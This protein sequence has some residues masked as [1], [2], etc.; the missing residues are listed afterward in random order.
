MK[1]KLTLLNLLILCSFLF[2]QSTG[3]ISGK[4]V[5]NNN[6]PVFGANVVIENMGTGAAADINGDY[7]IINIPPGTY[8]LKI[9]AIGYSASRVENVEINGG[10]T[11]KVN[12]ILTTSAVELNEIVVQYKRPP[13]QKDLTAKQQEFDA[14]DLKNMPIAGTVKDVLT[15]QAGITKDIVTIPV[16]SQ[17]VFGQFATIPNDGLHFRG[18]R[19][20]E[21]LYLFDGIPVNDNLWG[22]YNLD[23]IGTYSLQSMRILTGT[24]G[25]Q[26]GE[27]MSGVVEMQPLDN[28]VD[29]YS[30]N[31]IAS[32]D[33][34]GENSGSENTRSY[35]ASVSGPVAGLKNFSFFLNAR[36]YQT[37]GY[38]FGY[39]YPDYVDSR[40]TDKT[41]SPQKVP[42]AFRDN[43]FFFGKLLYQPVDALKLGVGFYT[44]ETVNGMY[45]HFFKYNPYGTPNQYLD[46]YLGY[47]KVT[48]V[49][50]PSTYYEVILSD[51]SRSFDSHVY[52][53]P[54]QYAVIPQNSTS[55]FSISGED[56]VYF[57]SKFEKS[58]AQVTFSS[59]V[60]KQQFIKAGASYAKLNTQL[61]RLNP[62]GFGAIEDYDF[63]P[64][65]FSAYVNDKMEFEDIGMVIN[66]GLRYDYIDPN[67]TFIK[68][69]TSPD[70]EVGKVKARQYVSPRFGISYPIS[71]AAA[72]RFGYGHYYQYP[73]F[74]KAFQGMNRQ[75]SLYPS[76]DVNSV[77]GAIAKGDIEEE[78]TINYEV[79]VQL[80][81][82]DDISADITGFYRKTY[83]LIGITITEGYLRS[84]DVVKTQKYPIF[85]NV[86][87]ATVQGIE[88]S[89]QKRLTGVFSGFINYTYS[90][91]LVSSSLVLS[92]PQDV[93]RTF[94]ADWDQ[95]HTAS[96]GAIFQFPGDWGFSFL[97]SASSGLPYT[98]NQYRPNAERA[99][100]IGS[101]DFMAHKEFKLYGVGLRITGQVFNL[102]NRRNI[103]WVYPDS[104][105][106]GVDTN[107]ATSD[108]YTN[109]PTMWGPGRR[110]QLGL[111][112]SY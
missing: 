85:D 103:W 69:I 12:V 55:E 47:L 49:L 9:S 75:Y 17:P 80:K 82:T 28:V 88:I 59:Q 7:F 26:Y 66:A 65:K 4:I 29:K 35:E 97:G 104:G 51:Y 33:E 22:G 109:N 91:A 43:R 89:I 96:F 107:L 24:F 53:T 108:D 112:I 23:V 39:I 30:F 98:Y 15:K 19:T 11:T 16:T 8:N 60:T 64:T 54:E 74:Y 77:S 50:S 68:N 72:F 73:D 83:N 42:M 57:D 34:F 58:E 101:F 86:N 14:A 45:N 25:P 100:W 111:S 5:D 81:V 99:P 62:D 102:F 94:P 20:N 48:H 36:A 93:T 105:Q 90:E 38:V 31:A 71:D 1:L 79:G 78:K 27:A 40:G 67:R 52:D 92:Q 87:F 70:G 10:L 41:G 21:T 44:A 84:G 3:K 2:P 18:G 61:K 46:D 37:D 76:P 110:M 106:P 95:P 32:T 63:K 56:W 6:E 13:V